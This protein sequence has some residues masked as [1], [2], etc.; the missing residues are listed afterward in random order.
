MI[1]GDSHMKISRI[2]IVLLVM[3]LLTSC[4]GA[5]SA[6]IQDGCKLVIK[7]DHGVVKSRMSM[8]ITSKDMYTY[9]DYVYVGGIS[10][11]L[12]YDIHDPV[13]AKIVKS[14]P[15]GMT[16]HYTK[17]GKYLAM[18]AGQ[19]FTQLR[20]DNPANPKVIISYVLPYQIKSVYKYSNVV[21][22]IKTTVEKPYLYLWD[23]GNVPQMSIR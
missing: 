16:T 3:L 6:S 9:K 10:S 23:S 14:L 19:L 20:L 17:N 22:G 13:K 21:V 7:D 1:D 11:T 15:Y 12:V 8:P 18:G 5:N 2:L 4:A